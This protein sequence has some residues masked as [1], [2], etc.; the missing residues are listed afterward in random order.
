MKSFDTSALSLLLFRSSKVPL[1]FRTHAPITNARERMDELVKELGRKAEKILI[2][3]PALGEFLVTAVFAG[4][5][6]QDYLKIFQDA[7]HF[8]TKP[9][10]VRAAVEIAERLAAAIKAGDK[11]E[12][13]KGEP[14]ERLKIDRQI[15]AISIVEGATAIYSADKHIHNQG[16]RWGIEVVSPADLPVPITQTELFDKK[17]EPT[18]E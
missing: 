18:K 15:I 1:D 13:E 7:Q 17:E 2:P 3:D 9:F 14:W 10:G 4:A 12:G 6:I 16:A 8:V 5:S 11:R